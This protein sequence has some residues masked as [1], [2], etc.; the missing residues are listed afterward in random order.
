MEM[1][2]ASITDILSW[3]LIFHSCSINNYCWK[4]STV[5]TV[6]STNLLY[7]GTYTLLFWFKPFLIYKRRTRHHTIW[8]VPCPD[9]AK[10]HRTNSV[11]FCRILFQFVLFRD[12]SLAYWH[13]MRIINF[14]GSCVCVFCFLITF[15]ERV[16]ERERQRQ[17][18]NL[19]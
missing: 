6:F 16:T 7:L 13:F 17:R 11:V 14:M 9:Q 12:I 5:S 1:Y 18:I 2:T 3:G 8:Q 15:D 19:G 10:Q 4:G